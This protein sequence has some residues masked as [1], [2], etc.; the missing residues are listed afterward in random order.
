M[1]LAACPLIF[2]CCPYITRVV[3]YNHSPEVPYCLYIIRDKYDSWSVGE[4][5]VSM[6]SIP[7][8]EN[9]H[10]AAMWW[11]VDHVASN[12]CGVREVE[13]GGMVVYIVLLLL[14]LFSL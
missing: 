12:Q 10:T 2:F 7:W 9:Q 1:L 3:V 8:H 14:F 5:G 13:G 6:K 4:I 11:T